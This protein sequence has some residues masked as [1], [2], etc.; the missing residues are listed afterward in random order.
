MNKKDHLLAFLILSSFSILR[1]QVFLPV[2]S[3]EKKPLIVIISNDSNYENILYQSIELNKTEPVSIILSNGDKENLIQTNDFV[4]QILNQDSSCINTDNIYFGIVGDSLFFEKNNRLELGI[5]PAQFYVKT[6]NR[7]LS[8]NEYINLNVEDFKLEEIYHRIKTKFL[9]GLHKIEYLQI[10]EKRSPAPAQHFGMGAH[11]SQFSSQ[12]T[13]NLEPYNNFGLNG[14]YQFNEHW[15]INVSLSASVKKPNFKR[16]LRGQL[17]PSDIQSGNEIELSINEQ[18]EIRTH[19]QS[20]LEIKRYLF[21][22]HNGIKLYLGLGISQLSINQG[23]TFLD[24]TITINPSEF[25]GSGAPDFDQNEI[26]DDFKLNTI[27]TMTIPLNFGI[28]LHSSR[29][30]LLNLKGTYM[31]AEPFNSD[32]K[33]SL[34]IEFGLSFKIFKQK[35][36]RFEYLHFRD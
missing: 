31:L 25:Q 16:L 18:I 9:W 29:H 11:L 32:L 4:N 8:P 36:K 13:Y 1:G 27:K 7:N 12:S 28:E 22:W 33:N 10:I 5:F 6:D 26:A 3:V 15:S 21:N 35:N 17:N 30:A 34:N 14:F 23:S 20:T 2:K 24:T 19:L